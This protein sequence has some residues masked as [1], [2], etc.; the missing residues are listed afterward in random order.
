[1]ATPRHPSQLRPLPEGHGGCGRVW[2]ATAGCWPPVGQPWPTT[3]RPGLAMAMLGCGWPR[4]AG[5]G[6][7]AL[8]GCLLACGRPWLDNDLFVN[9]YR[10]VPMSGGGNWTNMVTRVDDRQC[11]PVLR[12]LK[13]RH[14]VD[15]PRVAKAKS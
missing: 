3:G 1:V 2:P 7:C 6:S 15:R 5:P 11:L 13:R 10:L 4:L 8:A 9:I 12:Q 14:G